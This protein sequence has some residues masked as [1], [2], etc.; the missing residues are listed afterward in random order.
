M[1][2]FEFWVSRDMC[3]RITIAARTR[4][5][6]RQIVIGRYAPVFIRSI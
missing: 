5:I 4:E 6:A 1:Y 2:S 3:E